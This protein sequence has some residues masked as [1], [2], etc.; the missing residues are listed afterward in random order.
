MSELL[1]FGTPLEAIPFINLLNH[2]PK[3]L[4]SVNFAWDDA[5]AVFR[6]HILK[7]ERM[8]CRKRLGVGLMA[9]LVAAAASTAL[10]SPAGKTVGQN[11]V[12]N[13][14]FE[15]SSTSIP[16]WAVSGFIAQGFDFLL[17]TNPADAH[18]GS[19]SFAG[20]GIGAPGFIS[21]NIPTRPG[22]NYTIDLWLANLSGFSD[23]TELQVL[24]GGNL[25]FDQTDIL[26][27][28]YNHIVI[29][30]MATGP[31][32]ALSIGL[33][34]DSFFL[35]VDDISVRQVPEPATLAL[36]LGGLAAAGMARRRRST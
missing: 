31:S 27:F 5:G 28:G 7:G 33:R 6:G 22:Q 15:L 12:Q 9:A 11:L 26:G 34:D 25:I 30:P 35:N 4:S 23:G 10:A 16:F 19:N 29:D 13:P 18:T 1:T 21:Q 20:G 3:A 2:R 17:D 24:W 14:G 36:A 32:T 8:N